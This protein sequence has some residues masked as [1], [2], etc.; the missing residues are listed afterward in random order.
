MTCSPSPCSWHCTPVR[1]ESRSWRRP[2]CRPPRGSRSP[3]AAAACSAH[4]GR[5][6]ATRASL[7]TIARVTGRRR[8]APSRSGPSST[9]SIPTRACSF[10]TTGSGA[11]TGGTRILRR[12]RTTRSGTFPAARRHRSAAAASRCGARPSPIAN[13][14]SSNTT[15]TP[16]CPVVARRS[17]CTTT[18]GI[19]PTAASRCRVPAPAA[20]ATAAPGCDDLDQRGRVSAA[21]ASTGGLA[22]PVRAR[23]LPVAAKLHRAPG[24]RSVRRVVVERPVAVAARLEPLP[25]AVE[26]RSEGEGDDAIEPL[27][28]ARTPRRPSVESS[29]DTRTAAAL[30]VSTALV[31]SGKTLFA[32]ASARSASR[33]S[34]A[35]STSPASECSSSQAGSQ[36]TSFSRSTLLMNCCTARS[37][38]GAAFGTS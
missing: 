6:S 17:S 15:R 35:R 16:P 13:S 26:H 32:S 1:S 11:A 31:S 7:R 24:C 9:A 36:S 8:S 28:G 25:A 3:S 14:R 5:G 38:S 10:A 34:R 29:S 20:A 27:R 19:R 2:R 12:R 22:A 37:G 33:S 23:L 18:A 21:A 30:M 4:G